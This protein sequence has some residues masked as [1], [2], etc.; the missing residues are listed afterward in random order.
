MEVEAL[1]KTEGFPI[2]EDDER[3]EIAE[4]EIS[5]DSKDI[6]EEGTM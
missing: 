2:E 6:I 4:M 5:L 1:V 3:T